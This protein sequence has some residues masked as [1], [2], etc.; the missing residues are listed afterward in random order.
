MEI[1]Q[2]K[3]AKEIYSARSL[4]KASMR[5][6]KAASIVSRHLT[7]F[8]KECGGQNLPPHGTRRAA[9]RSWANGFRRRS[10]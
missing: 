8:E 1:I 5:L 2:L 6:G 9:H 10:M 7:A 4:T 3:I